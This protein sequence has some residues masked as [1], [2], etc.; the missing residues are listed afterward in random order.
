MDANTL[1]LE[2]MAKAA[3][4]FKMPR[5]AI[6]QP[7][8]VD[9]KAKAQQ[10]LIDKLAEQGLR[11]LKGGMDLIAE[12][13]YAGGMSAKKIVDD[14]NRFYMKKQYERALERY[15]EAISVDDSYGDSFV[16]LGRTYN[17]LGKPELALQYSN[18]ALEMDITNGQKRRVHK[19]LAKSYI[20]LGDKQNA[21]KHID[22]YEEM[23]LQQGKMNKR[24][25]KIISRLR[26]GL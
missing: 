4:A 23:T 6:V 7:A 15:L 12:D 14:G 8:T 11:L 2:Y 24:I 9:Y 22:M 26:N 25:R 5:A 16:M 21:K 1:N 10:S 18:K 13:A 3:D 17:H 20:A 19:D